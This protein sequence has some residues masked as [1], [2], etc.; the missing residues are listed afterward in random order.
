MDD[1]DRS[2]DRR[3]LNQAESS[4]LLIRR[5]ARSSA[6]VAG[7]VSSLPRWSPR[8][9]SDA[10]S[11]GQGQPAQPR[12]PA[13]DV[14]IGETPSEVEQQTVAFGLAGQTFEIDLDAEHAGELRSTLQRYVDAG[15]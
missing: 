13:A 8:H 1:R 12:T 11:D 2:Q 10:V 15:R 7:E 14:V 9:L 6:W 4:C 5:L 3:A